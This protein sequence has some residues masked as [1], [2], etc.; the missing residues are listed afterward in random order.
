ME[1]CEI[2]VL[3]GG[4]SGIACCSILQ[5]E[6]MDCILIEK[7][8]ELGG[9]AKTR[10]TDGFVFDPHGGHVFNTK[11]DRVREWVF[12]ALPRPKWQHS[13]RIAKILYS[14]KIIS[15]PFELALHE[16][17]PEEATECIMGIFERKG[18]EPKTFGKWLAWN[19]GGPIANKYLIPYNAKIWRRDLSTISTHWVSG[20]MPIPSPR[21]VLYAALSRNASEQKMVHSSYYYP[22]QGGIGKFTSA[23]AE[24][25]KNVKLNCPLTS[26]EGKAGE[27]IVNGSVRAQRIVSTLPMPELFK[28]LNDVPRRVEG[29]VSRLD[30]NPITTILCTQASGT[31][32][33]WLYLPGDD[34]SAHRI[35][36]Q[37]SFAS[38]NC[39]DG[40]FSATYEITGKHTPESI[41]RRF[42]KVDLPDEVKA[43][44][45]LDHQQTEYAYPVFTRTSYNDSMIIKE[46]LREQ[47]IESCGRFAEWKFM[48]MDDCIA[49]AFDVREKLLR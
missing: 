41:I 22:Q 47:G 13:P 34:L 46:W 49:R 16:L 45:V 40:K 32:L 18:K 37:G 9:L 27:W 14:G 44:D 2:V 5:S 28:V 12:S 42:R 23:A 43:F 1:T 24:N 36:Y 21:D 19:F 38:G 33:S 39:P 10:I 31:D 8:K 26:L 30:W 20:K 25:L 35:V 7:E 4:L 11:N 29:C 3:G 17:S 48:N 15:Y 6:G